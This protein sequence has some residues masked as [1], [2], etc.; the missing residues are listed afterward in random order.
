MIY[1]LDAAAFWKLSALCT[2]TAAAAER[3]TA[4]RDA[5]LVA[6]RA[7]N[8]ELARVAAAHGFDPAV[9]QFALDDEALTLTI[10][11]PGK[12]PV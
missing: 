6:Q 4:A 2:R 1:T 11:E 7:Q 5:A 10:P 9:E 12:A 8:A 3:A